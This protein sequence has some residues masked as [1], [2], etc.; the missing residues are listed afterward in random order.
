MNFN[1]LREKIKTEEYRDFHKNK[2]GGADTAIS[3]EYNDKWAN[4]EKIFYYQTKNAAAFIWLIEEL[5]S[6]VCVDYISKYNYY[7]YLM[8]TIKQA[9]S[10]CINIKEALNIV[11]DKI[12]EEENHYA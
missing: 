5:K 9:D 3:V 10:E 7:L 2:W 8:E 1:E 6:I 4:D 12:E 11:L